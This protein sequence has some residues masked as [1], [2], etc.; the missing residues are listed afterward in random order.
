[1]KTKKKKNLVYSIPCID[2]EKV[3][4]GEI[5]RMK[6]TLMKEHKAKIK[7]L[8]SDSKLVE[9]IILT[10][11]KFLTYYYRCCRRCSALN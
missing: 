7:T 4:I 2:C 6:E 1:M 3:Y 5:I 9:H 8:S 10:F 11:P